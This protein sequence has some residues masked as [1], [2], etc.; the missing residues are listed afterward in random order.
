[1]SLNE[2]L[3]KRRALRSIEKTPITAD[4][5]DQ[6]ATAAGLAPSCFNKQPWRYVFVYDEA[7]LKHLHPALSAGNAWAQNGSLIVAV[8]TQK[9]LDCVL[10]DREYYLF[11][12]G[13]AAGFMMLKAVELGLVAHPI[14]GFSQSQA[15]QILNIPE[16]MSL[17]T[18]I[19]FGKERRE[20]DPAFTL[21]QIQKERNR[22]PRMPFREFV[23]HN[24]Y[25]G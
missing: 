3:H 22:P 11:D 24:R 2:L 10:Q 20:I 6:L 15:R 13:M 14:A 8:C 7:M 12:N 17:I 18:L 25:G 23:F 4:I 1:M 5:I 16:D 19:V 21:E 9:D